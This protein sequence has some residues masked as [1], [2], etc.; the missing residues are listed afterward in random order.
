MMPK[1]EEEVSAE[2]ELKSHIPCRLC[3]EPAL[4]R[5]VGCESLM[6]LDCVHEV[7]AHYEAPHNRG[8]RCLVQLYADARMDVE[9][10]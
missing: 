2:F 8:I 6:C 4:I 9:E 10:A 1:K 7:S 5:C 3:D